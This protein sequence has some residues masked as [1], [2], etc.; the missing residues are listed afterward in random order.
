MT[1]NT[2]AF[3]NATIIDDHAAVFLYFRHLDENFGSFGV[4]KKQWA[5]IIERAFTLEELSNMLVHAVRHLVRNRDHINGAEKAVAHIIENIGIWEEALG[6]TMAEK[7]FTHLDCDMI[8]G[9]YVGLDEKPPYYIAD[10]I[11]YGY[12]Y[13]IEQGAVEPSDLVGVLKKFA[14]IGIMPSQDL[15]DL[16]QEKMTDYIRDCDITD[17]YLDSRISAVLY[18]I[19]ILAIEPEQELFDVCRD[20]IKQMRAQGLYSKPCITMTLRLK[21]VRSVK[22]IS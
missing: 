3:K 18:S 6:Y 4:F 5:Q 20:K 22:M 7:G 12:A 11:D 10:S 16:W 1:T 17:P 2:V 9:A 15:R 13:F 21:A 8:L 14:D 19:A